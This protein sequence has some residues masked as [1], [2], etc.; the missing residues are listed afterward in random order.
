MTPDRELQDLVLQALDRDPRVTPAGIG[1]VVRHAVVM[2]FGP[3]ET[4]QE[5][6]AAEAAA[7][8]VPGVRAVVNGLGVS[9]RQARTDATIAYE[10]SR[11]LAWTSA[12]PLGAVV[13]TVW[14]GWVTLV[15]F[16]GSE[17]QRAAAER[18]VRRIAGVRGLFNAIAISGASA[19][20]RSVEAMVM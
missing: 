9:W 18:T 15:G 10:A 19:E 7:L 12:V 4:L 3:V 16:V 17:E 8:H 11:A 13:P 1:I 20:S 6:L 2:L 14:D 5:R